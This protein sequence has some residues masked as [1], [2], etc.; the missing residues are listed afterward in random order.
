MELIKA[1]DESRLD[2][3]TLLETDIPEGHQGSD[4]IVLEWI[5][6]MLKMSYKFHDFIPPMISRDSMTDGC[7][8]IS[9]RLREMTEPEKFKSRLFYLMGQCKIYKP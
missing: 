6:H 4:K 8:I 9:I 1:T 3:L 5:E 2:T 7:R